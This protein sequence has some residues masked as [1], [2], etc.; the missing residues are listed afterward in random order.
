MKLLG[1]PL[2]VWH[3]PQIPC[4]P[5]KVNVKDEYEAY[6]IINTLADQHIWLLQNRLIPDYANSFE[7]VMNFD[8]KTW[9]PYYNKE[10]DMS[11]E[12]FELIY[13]DEIIQQID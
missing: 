13:E 12:D 1:N 9:E 7:V 5:F 6:K 4:D 2:Q 3:Y 8:G 10:E 11:W